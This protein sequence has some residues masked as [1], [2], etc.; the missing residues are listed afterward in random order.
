M[1]WGSGPLL[2]GKFVKAC[3]PEC[4]S[5]V[6]W[7]LS[8]NKGLIHEDMAR[9]ALTCAWRDYVLFWLGLCACSWN[10]MIVSLSSHIL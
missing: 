9:S 8:G 2:L 7:L 5:M 3:T 10:E 1:F 6:L 4:I